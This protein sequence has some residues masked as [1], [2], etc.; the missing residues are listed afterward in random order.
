[1]LAKHDVKRSGL[2]WKLCDVGGADLDHVAE[3]DRV[4]EPLGDFAVL[5]CEVDGG[6]TGASLGGDQPGGP[7][8]SGAGVEDTVA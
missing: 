6:D 4:V 3:P 1:M 5:G 2:E 7:A 8:D